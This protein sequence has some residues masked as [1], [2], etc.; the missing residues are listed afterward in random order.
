MVRASRPSTSA[1]V[2]VTAMSGLRRF[3]WSVLVLNVAVILLGALVR[4]T[5]SGA[6]CGRSWPVCRGELIPP[7]GGAT[8]FEF[9]HRVGSGLALLAVLALAVAVVK[10]TGS[11]HGARRSVGLSVLA[12]VGEALIGAAIVAYEWVADDAS[13][14]RAVAVPLHLVNTLVLLAAL[15]ATTSRL[16]GAPARRL[17]GWAIWGGVGLVIV[18]ALGAVAALADT[19]FPAES[20]AAGLGADWEPAQHFLTRLRVLHPVVAVV[21][22]GAL[23][24]T[25][26]QRRQ[27]SAARAVLVLVAIQVGVG[28]VNVLL[29]TPVWMQ[30]VHLGIADAL[31]VAWV[32]L[33]IEA[34]AV[35]SKLN[36]DDR[37]AAGLG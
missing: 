4:A 10:A 9:T 28:I 11:S 31:W 18:A 36:D 25:A 1:V 30:L 23:V 8:A 22:G 21:V 17:P 26:T 12:I 20:I 16:A 2:K 35:A 5:G 34:P 37:V 29:L 6:G 19:L 32:L 3:A 15:T 27:S 13:I 24:A 7:L 33:A 14:A